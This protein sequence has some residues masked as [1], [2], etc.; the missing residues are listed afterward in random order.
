V[1]KFVG[2]LF[3]MSDI[4]SARSAVKVHMAV[5]EEK[6]RNRGGI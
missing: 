6:K 5:L 2:E 4:Q 3:Q 1:Q